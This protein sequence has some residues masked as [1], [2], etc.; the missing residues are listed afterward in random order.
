MDHSTNTK[1]FSN[2]DDAKDYLKST[3]LRCE[4][5][6]VKK[7]PK[8][9]VWDLPVRTSINSKYLSSIN[10][11]LRE[12]AA[13]F[14][15]GKPIDEESPNFS[16]ENSEDPLERSSE[17]LA[18]K[19]QVPNNDEQSNKDNEDPGEEGSDKEKTSDRPSDSDYEPSEE[20][21]SGKSHLRKGLFCILCVFH[22]ERFL[23]LSFQ[24]EKHQ[25]V[26]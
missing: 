4:W 18:S 15:V 12:I 1:R 11:R 6:S 5:D 17:E 9:E 10:F 16:R 20:S 13:M 2:P 26:L 7:L 19:Q 14:E 23:I 22:K 3:K 25:P 21:D 8:T 24:Q